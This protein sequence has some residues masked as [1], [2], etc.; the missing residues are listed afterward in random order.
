MATILDE[1]RETRTVQRD[2]ADAIALIERANARLRPDEL[3][4]PQARSLIEAYGR[5][6]KLG[7]FGV[8]SLSPGVADPAAVA[9]ASGSSIPKARDAVATGTTIGSSPELDAALR[10]GARCRSTRRPR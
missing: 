5:I 3:T 1:E 7:G 6:V 8:A 9:R 4:R 2:I 10:Q